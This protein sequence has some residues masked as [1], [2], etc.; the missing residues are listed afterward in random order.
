MVPSKHLAIK[1]ME[2][3]TLVFKLIQ[4]KDFHFA[5]LGV[6]NVKQDNVQNVKNVLANIMTP[7]VHPASLK[8]LT[9]NLI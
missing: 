9:P 6:S 3:E 5:T 4:T 2:L 8:N 1:I 7:S